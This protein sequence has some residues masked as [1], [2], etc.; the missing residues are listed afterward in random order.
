[1]N[2]I[3]FAPLHDIEAR[4]DASE[5]HVPLA[6][7]WCKK[8]ELPMPFLFDNRAPKHVRTRMVL[9]ELA[10]VRSKLDAVAFFG[11]G[12]HKSIAAGFEKDDI[13]SLARMLVSVLDECGSVE[14]YAPD[15]GIDSS[16]L[17][18]DVGFAN[19]LRMAMHRSGKWN[20]HVIVRACGPG[21]NA[22]AR[23]FEGPLEDSGE[24]LAA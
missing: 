12:S 11:W 10:R 23:A 14:I 2:G 18:S 21:G 17:C 9:R 13:E 1:M 20:G 6:R 4:R 22:V 5:H 7:A 24:W 19:V 16:G 3:C 8:H 15:P